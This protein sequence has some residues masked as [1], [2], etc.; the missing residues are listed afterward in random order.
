MSAFNIGT[1]TR[2]QVAGKDIIVCNVKDNDGNVTKEVTIWK[3]D[4]D[5]K[6]FPGFDQI[7]TGSVVEGNLWTKPGTSN[8]TLYPPKD[9]KT[10][11][12]GHTKA[13]MQEKTQSIAKF[14]ETKS[15]SIE[16]AQEVNR[17]MYAKKSAAEIIAHHPAYKDLTNL[18]LPQIFMNLSQTIYDFDP[19][20]SLTGMQKDDIISHKESFNRAVATDEITADEIPW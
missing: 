7:D 13:L 4:K 14:Q 5:G 3:T 18:N 10:F 17:A 20:S 11:G 9:K 8:V 12:S 6:V 15:Q 19:N 1:M 2:K 16:K